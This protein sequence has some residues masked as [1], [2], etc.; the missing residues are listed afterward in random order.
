M[1]ITKMVIPG[2]FLLNMFIFYLYIIFILKFI[3]YFIIIKCN[4]SYRKMGIGDW[5]LGIWGLGLGPNPQPPTPNPPP[6]NPQSPIPNPHL[7][8]LLN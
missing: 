6:P 8:E 1:K 2:K 5:G 3:L 4:K 7:I